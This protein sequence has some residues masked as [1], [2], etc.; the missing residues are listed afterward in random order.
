MSG[1]IRN[2][3]QII[4]QKCHKLII[5]LQN[6]TTVIESATV[7][8]ARKSRR[9]HLTVQETVQDGDTFPLWVSTSARVYQQWAIP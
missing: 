6:H 8:F 3:T 4:S 7:V 5:P 9:T 2:T 1:I